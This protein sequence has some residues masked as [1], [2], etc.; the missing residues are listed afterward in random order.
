MTND[1]ANHL[2]SPPLPGLPLAP[3]IHP[4]VQTCL[5]H[6]DLLHQLIQLSVGPVHVILPHLLVDNLQRL[7][8]T[9]Q[10]LGV[11]THLAYAHK[12]NKS[13]AF[14]RAARAGGFGIDVASTT[15]LTNA[16]AAGFT[17][18][19]I[20][21][22][23][24][25]NRAFLTLA[26]SH[27]CLISVDSRAELDTLFALT[28]A[29]TPP[30]RILLRVA[31]AGQSSDNDAGTTSLLPRASGA[32]Q[33]R[34]GLSTHELPQIFAELASQNRVCFEGLHLHNYEP[35][36]V[37]ARQAQR[38]LHLCSQAQQLGLQP[39]LLNMGG[40][41]RPPIVADADQWSRFIDALC[42]Q[43]VHSGSPEHPAAG[44]STRAHDH[45]LTWRGYAYGLSLNHQGRVTGRDHAL[46]LVTTEEPEQ[47]LRQILRQPTQ[48]GQPLARVISDLMLTVMLEPGMLA[49]DQAGFSLVE[50]LG[51]KTTAAG[52]N[53][54]I[55][56][57]H[58]AN[59][60]LDMQEQICDPILLPPPPGAAPPP[61]WAPYQ[62]VVVGTLCKEADI[63]LPRTVTFP[64]QPQE[65]DVLCL[66]NTAGYS[67]DFSD[68][69]S[70]GHPVGT[71]RVAV[72]GRTPAT[73]VTYLHEDRYLP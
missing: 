65:A 17:G 44:Q 33:S 2:A 5:N 72:L 23:G 11:H 9:C 67:S 18:A 39:R 30:A 58:A 26:L 20:S 60:S 62:A 50:V 10:S 12:P 32:G 31:D 28:T 25:K 43:L 57:A 1:N 3:R 53:L 27:G 34:F 51:T 21:C 55:V 66:V 38:L 15:E 59:L 4:D 54:V 14:A 40:G 70:L 29:T 71:K 48:W 63:V 56:Q 49:F 69:P 35:V 22:T 7:Q 46:G 68:S 42:S 8:D 19:D 41:L 6:P 37:K 64:R 47:V 61:S 52:T 16:L 36:A 45:P 73:A 24:P 13:I